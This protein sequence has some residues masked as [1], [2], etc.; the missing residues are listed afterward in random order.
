MAITLSED[1]KKLIDR[2]NFV[3]ARRSRA[4]SF[5]YRLPVARPH[6]STK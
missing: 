3:W 1:A 6:W 4:F 5:R 2:P